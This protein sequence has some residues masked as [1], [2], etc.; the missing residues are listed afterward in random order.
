MIPTTFEEWKYC[1]VNDCKIKLTIAFI[2]SRL[3]V[4]QAKGNPETKKFVKLYGEQHLQNVISW[5][6]RSASEQSI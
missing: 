5:L 2:H 3:K 4:Y 1:I 6:K